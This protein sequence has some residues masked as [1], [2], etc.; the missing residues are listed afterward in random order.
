MPETAGRLDL[1]EAGEWKRVS[2]RYVVVEIVGTVLFG[3]A[4]CA[5]ASALWLV[6]D[7]QWAPYLLA[8]IIVITAV[9]VAFEPR[10][11]RAI[12]YQLR[13]DDL[14]FRRGIMFTRFVSVP[15]GRMQLVD[16]T[17]GP[18]AR[19][20]GLADLKFVTAA[21]SSGVLIPG[22]TEADAESLRDA[23]VELAESRRAGL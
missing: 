21:A 3:L 4:L 16:I 1:P 13:Q 22:L 20:L 11:V 17:R 6:A 8:A 23:L 19:R 9:T 5:A 18:I 12:G 10:R 7:V 2:P 15:Y 14:L